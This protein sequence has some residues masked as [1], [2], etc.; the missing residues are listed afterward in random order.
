MRQHL[1]YDDVLRQPLDVVTPVQQAIVAQQLRRLIHA[2][3][4]CWERGLIYHNWNNP[5]EFHL[6]RIRPG[7]FHLQIV[8]PVYPQNQYL[9]RGEWQDDERM[10]GLHDLG[11]YNLM[12]EYNLLRDELKDRPVKWQGQLPSHN[13]ERSPL[14]RQVMRIVLRRL[15]HMPQ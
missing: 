1:T 9:L 10:R 15:P 3:S 4:I 11:R 5:K 14:G 13:D 8:H 6:P 2:A 7:L 12:P